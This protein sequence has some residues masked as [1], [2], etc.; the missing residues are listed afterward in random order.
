MGPARR[1]VMGH[2]RLLGTKTSAAT[3]EV[4]PENPDPGAIGSAEGRSLRLEP[5]SQVIFPTPRQGS[6][7]SPHPG[8][9]H[10]L[11]S[12]PADV[13]RN[14][15]PSSAIRRRFDPFQAP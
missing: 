9:Y 14:T 4:V 12:L 5:A 2:S 8:A 13:P 11:W 15:T 7:A 3:P 1:E 10:A 6:V